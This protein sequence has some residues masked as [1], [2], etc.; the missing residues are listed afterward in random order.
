MAMFVTVI[1]NKNKII[2][3]ESLKLQNMK[4]GMSSG[5]QKAAKCGTCH[6]F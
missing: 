3:N 5:V 2:D 1:N 4:E 6:T